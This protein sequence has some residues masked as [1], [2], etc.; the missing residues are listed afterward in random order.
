MKK[1]YYFLMLHINYRIWQ[2]AMKLSNKLWA[3]A[4]AYREKF[5]QILQ[6][7]YEAKN[8]KIS[9]AE[10]KELREAKKEAK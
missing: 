9:D 4:C 7:E 3:N 10:L 2:V 5:R 1:P 8:G 6:K